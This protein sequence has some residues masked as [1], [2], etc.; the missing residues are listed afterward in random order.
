VK[1]LIIKHSFFT[2]RLCAFEAYL[3]FGLRFLWFVITSFFFFI[4]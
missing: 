3:F 1:Q 2:E 4:G